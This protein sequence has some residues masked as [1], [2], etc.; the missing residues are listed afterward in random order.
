[1][2]SNHGKQ[3]KGAIVFMWFNDCHLGRCAFQTRAYIHRAFDLFSECEKHRCDNRQCL[4]AE[5]QDVMCNNIV[6]CDDGSDEQD[7]AEPVISMY[8][9]YCVLF[10]WLLHIHLPAN[11]NMCTIQYK[12]HFALSFRNWILEVILFS[13]GSMHMYNNKTCVSCEFQTA[14]CW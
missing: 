7:C 8:I 3:W 4:D 5:T 2:V 12:S 9:V 11:R 13:N 10:C 1:M 6:Q 14:S